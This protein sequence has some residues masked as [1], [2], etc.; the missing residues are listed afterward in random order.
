MAK[1]KYTRSGETP[2]GYQCTNNKCKWQGSDKEKVDI[3]RPD[4]WT[5]SGCPECGNTE[6]FGL[7]VNP[8]EITEHAGN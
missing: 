5:E 4:G 7:L 1:R 8:N 2:Q 3:K 6:F